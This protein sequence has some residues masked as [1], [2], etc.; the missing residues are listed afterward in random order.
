MLGFDVDVFFVHV[1]GR[2]FFG[3]DFFG[4]RFERGLLDLDASERVDVRGLAVDGRGEAPFDD[5]SMSCSKVWSSAVSR[6]RSIMVAADRL[7]LRAVGLLGRDGDGLELDAVVVRGEAVT[8]A[9]ILDAP[10]RTS[11]RR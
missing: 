11:E 7:L 8:L 6:T 3:G 4:P 10:R 2:L 5:T 1:D 9:S